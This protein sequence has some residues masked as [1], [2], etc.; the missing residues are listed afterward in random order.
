MRQ[1]YGI[2][3]RRVSISPEFRLTESVNV[4]QCAIFSYV[5]WLTTAKL[6][7]ASL[8][9]PC[10][11]LHLLLLTD[12]DGIRSHSKSKRMESMETSCTTKVMRNDGECGVWKKCGEIRHF[13]TG[14]G[15]FAAQPEP[16]VAVPTPETP[17]AKQL[18]YAEPWLKIKRLHWIHMIW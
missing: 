15:P 11:A 2:W 12:A 8:L 16:G 9:V 13:G 5:T 18:K 14:E 6:S 17:V 10:A 4:Q 3:S 1:R 7:T